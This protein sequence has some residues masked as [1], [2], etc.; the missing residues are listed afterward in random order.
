L[1]ALG[2]GVITLP[3]QR[4]HRPDI[5][6]TGLTANVLA[7]QQARA[8]GSYEA[9]LV[10]ARGVVREGAATNAWIVRDGTVLTH[11][12]DGSIL[13]GVTRATLLE[14]MAHEGIVFSEA[15]F[16]A[17]DAYL[18]DEAFISGATT[19]VLPVTSIDEHVIGNGRAGSVALRLRAL[20]HA[21]AK[22]T[23]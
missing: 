16:T 22:L 18:A 19:L 10:D 17:K 3:D 11:P 15:A 8:G 2:V 20:F 7:R 1:A 23:C 12:A 5:K 14:L 13:P 4:W 21:F 9:W 6:T